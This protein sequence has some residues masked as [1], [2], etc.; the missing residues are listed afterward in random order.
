MEVKKNDKANIEK[1]KGIYFQLG[2]IIVLSLSLIAFEW[3]SG[4]SGYNH[5]QKAAGQVIDDDII[6]ITTLDEKPPEVKPPV[7]NFSDIIKVFQNDVVIETNVDI[8]DMFTMDEEIPIHIYNIED[9]PEEEEQ[10]PFIIVEDMPIFRGGDEN[11]FARWVQRNVRYPRVPSENGIQGRVFVEFVVEPDGTVSNVTVIKSVHPALD[12]EAV[13]VISNSPKWV[14]GR[15]LGVPVR[16][17]FT[18]TVSFQL[19]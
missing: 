2:L 5:Y 11:T 15:Q 4:T 7:P 6:P 17:R 9:E 10:V 16:V 18:I 19:Q 8:D 3:T 1:T 12:A 13:R 14:P